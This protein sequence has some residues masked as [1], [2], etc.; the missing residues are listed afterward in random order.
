MLFK[1]Y[2][3]RPNN[4]NMLLVKCI[5]RLYVSVVKVKKYMYF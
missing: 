4:S 1:L 5:Y 2:I 3:Y